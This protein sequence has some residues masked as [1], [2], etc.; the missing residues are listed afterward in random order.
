MRLYSNID[1]T[2]WPGMRN[3]CICVES[4]CE[5]LM[6]IYRHA[7]DCH[8][9]SYIG[10]ARYIKYYLQDCCYMHTLLH[11]EL[12]LHQLHTASINAWAAYVSPSRRY[13]RFKISCEIS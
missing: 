13:V 8:S 2:K 5:D 3:D 6:D 10:R 11:I 9:D 7:V 4:F 12:A 1:T